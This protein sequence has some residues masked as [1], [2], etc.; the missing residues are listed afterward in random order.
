MYLYCELAECIMWLKWTVNISSAFTANYTVIVFA[1][2]S[3]VP[4]VDG[5]AETL[6]LEERGL[7]NCVELTKN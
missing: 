6:T 3:Q 5:W 7:P 4:Q 2:K 1:C